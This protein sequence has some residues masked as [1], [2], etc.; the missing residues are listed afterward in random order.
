MF[1]QFAVG[2]GGFVQRKGARDVDF[3]RTRLDQAVELLTLVR[4]WAMTPLKADCIHMGTRS[5]PVPVFLSQRHQ[6][7]DSSGKVAFKMRRIACRSAAGK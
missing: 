5:M 3:K 7:L 6:S 1:V 4:D 2:V